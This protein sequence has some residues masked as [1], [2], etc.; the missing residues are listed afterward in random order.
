M[1]ARGS[2]LTYARNL[3]V[4]MSHRQP[5]VASG[6][7]FSGYN[8]YAYGGAYGAAG[9]DGAWGFFMLYARTDDW[10]PVST[11]AAWIGNIAV[12][13][14]Y[15]SNPLNPAV[16]AVKV[17]VDA[18]MASLPQ[19][20]YLSDNTGPGQT[21]SNQWGGVTFLEAATESAVREDTPP[22]WHRTFNYSIL[23]NGSVKS[24]V[25]ANAG[26]RPLERNGSSRDPVDFR[27]VQDALNGTGQRIKS[28]NDVGGYPVVPVNVRTY[29]V[30]AN[31]NGPGN[32]GTTDSGVARTIIECDLELKARALEPA[33]QGIPVSST[34][35]AAPKNVRIV[36]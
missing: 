12:R 33:S 15:S 20:L 4:H 29:P 13:G 2:S 6:S 35:P 11:E 17:W 7:R 10:S 1:L 19:K 22:T 16:K 8:N 31:P 32:C 34:P 26:A 9:D 5:W 24:Y 25:I 23:P 3:M 21:I 36:E 28:Q 18:A 14:N 30:P 27:V